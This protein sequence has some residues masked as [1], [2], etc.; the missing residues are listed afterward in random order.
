MT[1]LIVNSQ[2]LEVAQLLIEHGANVN[3]RARDGFTPL[4]NA[5]TT[6]LTRLL[7]EHGA[8]PFAKTRSETIAV[9]QASPD[10]L[11]DGVIA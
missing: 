7:L 1:P 3:A 10:L 11:A 5:G 4:I 8:D 6:E 9:V 2:D